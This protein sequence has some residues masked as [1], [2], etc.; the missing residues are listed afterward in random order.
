MM[1][2]DTSYPRPSRPPIVKKLKTGCIPV[3]PL[4]SFRDLQV[5]PPR[6]S[7]RHSEGSRLPPEESPRFSS[8][9]VGVCTSPLPRCQGSV[10]EA[11]ANACA[12][13]CWIIGVSVT[14]ADRCQRGR[15]V[16]SAIP[17]PRRPCGRRWEPKRGRGHNPGHADLTPRC[18]AAPLPVGRGTSSDWAMRRSSRG[19]EASPRFSS[20]YVGVCTSPLP[21]CRAP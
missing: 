4:A 12:Q 19:P 7:R 14:G 17:P 1:D 15:R 20:R 8:R 6:P 10:P 2:V 11:P 5:V 3:Y 21:R 9:R 16:G 13:A 18:R